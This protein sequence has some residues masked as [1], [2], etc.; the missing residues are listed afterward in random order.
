MPVTAKPPLSPP[1]TAELFAQIIREKTSVTLVF[2][3]GFDGESRMCSMEGTIV[4]N[5]GNMARFLIHPRYLPSISHDREQALPALLPVELNVITSVIV[6]TVAHQ[7][8]FRAAGALL[9]VDYGPDDKPSHFIFRVD[10]N[11]SFRRGRRHQRHAWKEHMRANLRLGNVPARP[12][13][14][15][16]LRQHLEHSLSGEDFRPQIVNISQGG[17]CLTVPRAFAEQP[18]I[19]PDGF[20]FVYTTASASEHKRPRIFLCRQAGVRP[21]LCDAETVALRLQFMQELDWSKST[22]MLV[23]KDVSKTGSATINEFFRQFPKGLNMW[24]KG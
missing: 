9:T 24:K 19:S 15:Y 11:L 1:T 10:D 20:L 17:I 6:G 23:W 8:L 16:D 13:T 21:D 5:E 2:P 18:G 14:L 22:E 12:D 7:I 4:E 3:A